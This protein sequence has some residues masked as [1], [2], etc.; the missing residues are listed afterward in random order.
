M[1]PVT[2]PATGLRFHDLSHPWGHG[3]PVWPG[4][5]GCVFERGSFHALHGTL[6][7]RF[8]TTMHASTHVNAPLHLVAGGASM[9]AVPLDHFFGR[10]VVLSI[11][12]DKWGLIEA[13]DL[14][15]AEPAAS[16]SLATP[17]MASGL[18]FLGDL[19]VVSAAKPSAPPAASAVS[20]VS[21][22]S[23]SDAALLAPESAA[24]L[25][26][27]AAVFLRNSS[28]APKFSASR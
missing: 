6:T 26:F 27:F 16:A 12:K 17:D 10:A 18:A 8:S 20:S 3:A 21:V 1:A 13:D 24:A 23:D 14:E 7:Q 19:L 25:A 4:F 22:S 2:D 5:P 28:S 9:G 11:P 15:A